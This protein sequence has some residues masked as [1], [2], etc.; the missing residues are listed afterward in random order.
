MLNVLIQHKEGGVATLNSIKPQSDY[1]FSCL[2]R[3]SEYQ[4]TYH[5]SKESTNKIQ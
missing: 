1:I 2:G 3:T 5:C 4:K